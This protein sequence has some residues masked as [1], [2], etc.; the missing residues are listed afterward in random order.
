[1]NGPQPPTEYGVYGLPRPPTIGGSAMVGG[2][3]LATRSFGTGTFGRLVATGMLMASLGAGAVTLTYLVLWLL[4]R[5]TGIPLVE[6]RLQ[7]VAPG[8]LPYG[9]LWQILSNLLDFAFFLLLVRLTPLAG[10]HAAEHKVVHAIERYG[11]ATPELARAMPRSHRRCGTTLLA[12][13]LPALLIA[14]PLL[15]VRPEVA[16]LVVLLGWLVRYRVGDV[17]QRYLTTKEPTERQ[18]AAGLQAGRD[19][20][21]R[22]RRDPLAR[23]SPMMSFWRRGLVQLLVGMVVAMQLYNWVYQHLYLWLDWER[24]LG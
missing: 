15:Y 17:I 11:Y 10:Y 20:L 12:G 13:I 3:H 22:W 4:G 1:M 5:L 21:D 14:S 16:V 23:V 18:L 24:W 6:F 7:I 8:Q 2:V 9:V 19:I